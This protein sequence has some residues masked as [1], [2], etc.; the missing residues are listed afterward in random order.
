MR[1]L[2]ASKILESQNFQP[3]ALY[4]LSA[5]AKEAGHE[6][7]VVDARTRAAVLRAIEAE[8]PDVLAVST[9]TTHYP[10]FQQVAEEAKRIWPDLLT[11]FGGVHVT[12]LPECVSDPGIDA[13]CRGEGDRAFPA[14][15][16]KI[17]S[18][19]P[20][21]DQVGFWFSENGTTHTNDV[22]PL[23]TDLDT[24]P[25]P[26]RSLTDGLPLSGDLPIGWFIPSRGCPFDCAFCNNRGMQDLY[27]VGAKYYR[28]LSAER[29]VSEVR[30]ACAQYRFRTLLFMSDV[31]ALSTSWLE[32]FVELYREGP[33]LPFWCMVR[34]TMFDE[35]RA[36]LLREA[37]CRVVE[38]GLE[39][40][41]EAYR[42]TVFG[43]RETNRQLIE[44]VR[45]AR[46]FG[47][48]VQTSNVLGA[49]GSRIEQ[50]LKTVALNL[51]ARPHIPKAYVFQPF[52]GTAL[53]PEA[54]GTEAAD[55]SSTSSPHSMFMPS[56]RGSLFASNPH[57]QQVERL[58]LLFSLAAMY[59]PVCRALPVLIRLPLSLLYFVGF[60]STEVW[61]RMRFIF[62]REFL[63][64]PKVIGR[65]LWEHA[66]RLRPDRWQPG[67]RQGGEPAA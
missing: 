45:L 10:F 61:F 27:G 8:H 19:E 20:Y 26:D 39:S 59:G 66:K 13:I 22:A 29:F 43:R 21:F 4:A 1:I 46:R 56:I 36:R 31:F 44:V 34:P 7:G 67:K 28:S 33:H 41:D 17:A 35:R 42:Q 58:A 3:P 60:V 9:I 57:Q 55:G 47:L 48:Y 63:A 38:M 52:P 16:D 23:I 30:D 15:L 6:T 64:R 5:T 49:P 12:L 51:A 32:R 40:G 11:V 25:V 65:L 37:N 14:L 54:T 53:S 18:G 2:F 62:G 50:D 24:L